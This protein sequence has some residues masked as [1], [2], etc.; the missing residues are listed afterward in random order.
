M[1]GS[2]TGQDL[3]DAY[4]AM[5]VFVFS[6]QSETQGMVLA[7]AM[8]A[9]TPVVA[10][11]GPGVRDVVNDPTAACSPPT[12]RAGLRRRPDDLTR[13]RDALG[14]LGESA[15][16]S[17]RDYSLDACADRMLTLYEQLI[18]QHRFAIPPPTPPPGTACSAAWKSNGTSSRKNHR[19][20]RRR[21]RF[22][23][24]FPA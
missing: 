12:P 11:D 6:S 16:Q 9:R 13:D 23:G 7:E 17:V 3:A 21:R 15:R 14:Q 1:P 2:Q 24:P 22:P 18:D 10:L 8:A 20:R 19:P 4:A 5:D